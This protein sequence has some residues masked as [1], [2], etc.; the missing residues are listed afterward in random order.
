MIYTL[1]ICAFF[2]I[3]NFYYLQ[4]KRALYLSIEETQNLT[5]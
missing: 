4:L 1:Q 5:K 3:S 2:K